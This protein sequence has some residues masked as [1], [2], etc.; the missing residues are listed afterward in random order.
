MKKK[1]LLFSMILLFSG[2]FLNNFTNYDNSA[3][4]VNHPN[5]F[6]TFDFPDQH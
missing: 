3:D 4:K 1:L 5:G 6:V 2:L